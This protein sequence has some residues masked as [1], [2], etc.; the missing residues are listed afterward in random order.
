MPMSHLPTN[1]VGYTKVWEGKPT[2]FIKII[3]EWSFLQGE[4]LKTESAATPSNIVLWV[5]NEWID[6]AHLRICDK[7]RPANTNNT[8]SFIKKTDNQASDYRQG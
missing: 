5:A 7:Y 3:K 2:E 4:Y 1:H 6:W 8:R